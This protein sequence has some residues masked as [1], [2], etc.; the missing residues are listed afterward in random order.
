[1]LLKLR[2]VEKENYE[3]LAQELSQKFRELPSKKLILRLED[4]FKNYNGEMQFESF[5]DVSPIVTKEF[6]YYELCFDFCFNNN[7]KE[8]CDLIKTK[9]LNDKKIKEL[10]SFYYKVYDKECPSLESVFEIFDGYKDFF[11]CMINFF[12]DFRYKYNKNYL[13]SHNIYTGLFKRQGLMNYFLNSLRKLIDLD[14]LNYIEIDDIVEKNTC[15]MFNK[16][17]KKIPNDEYLSNLLKRKY[18]QSP[19]M[20]TFYNIGYGKMNIITNDG[21][22]STI[23]A[24]RSDELVFSISEK[25]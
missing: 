24:N 14:D 22:I 12:V 15:Y 7:Y 16:L 4:F 20:R 9:E 3:I 17:R 1:M 5:V 2:D 13:H 6:N 10:K 19:F 25:T 21:N 8:F 23:R 18:I 11:E